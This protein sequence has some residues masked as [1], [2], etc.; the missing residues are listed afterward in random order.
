[1]RKEKRMIEEEA[2]VLEDIF[3][4]NEGDPKRLQKIRNKINKKAGFNA[5]FDLTEEEPPS[6]VQYWIPT[7]SRLLDSIIA[8]RNYSTKPLGIPGARISELA[9]CEGVG[10]TYLA[11]QIAKNAIEMG[12][13]VIY[14]D[15]EST[16][17]G[18]F[19]K[20]IGCKAE[21]LIYVLAPS[22][23]FVFETIKD[24]LGENKN[25]MLFIWDSLAATPCE[26][27]IDSD[28]DPLSSLLQKSRV[29]TKG[30]QKLTIPLARHQSTMLILNQLKDN[31]T[32]NS[33][34]RM[35]EPYKT[36]GGK[37]LAY[38]YSLRVW[39]TPHRAKDSFVY[40]ELKNKIGT[41][42]SC[43]IKK[44][45]F[46]TFGRSCSFQIVWGS[47]G[48]ACVKDEE[49]WL[50]PLKKSE[51]LI[52]GGP[53]YTLKYAD[54]TEEKFQS[55]NWTEKLKDPKFRSRALELLDEVLIR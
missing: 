34:E 10:K 20:K 47:D 15:S 54:G 9:A 25:K 43:L 3:E 6:K 14:F 4:D 29:I 55:I 32:S 40:D 37:S 38:S 17:E 39:L 18:E 30:L 5:S 1:M 27:D 36:S 16:T 28:F 44:N 23:E 22:V 48:I 12:M 50:E 2:T 19:V 33:I 49:S 35:M 51:Y 26:S 13:D 11:L 31:I 41:E 42:V 8:S 53:W 7:G 46:G 21:N 52:S 45:K 24:L